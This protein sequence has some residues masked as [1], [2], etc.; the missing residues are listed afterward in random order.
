MVGQGSARSAGQSYPFGRRW[1]DVLERAPHCRGGGA[2]SRI[3]VKLR[4][5]NWSERT[6]GKPSWIAAVL[7]TSTHLL[8]YSSWSVCRLLPLLIAPRDSTNP[9]PPRCREPWARVC[10][11]PVTRVATLCTGRKRPTPLVRA[12][13]RSMRPTNLLWGYG[14][15]ACALARAARA[16]LIL[17]GVYLMGINVLPCPDWLAAER[18]FG[19]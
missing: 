19:Q 5:E 3:R 9:P 2:V 1:C 12:H 13:M 10:L 15:F 8:Y 14:L 17:F 18:A 7:G 4:G 6:G 16:A 11:S